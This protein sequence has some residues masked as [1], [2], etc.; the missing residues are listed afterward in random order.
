MSM[1]EENQPKTADNDPLLRSVAEQGQ[2]GEKREE[3]TTGEAGDE[4]RGGGA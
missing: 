2:A 4:G 1:P 3:D